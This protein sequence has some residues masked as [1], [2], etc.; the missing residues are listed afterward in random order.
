MYYESQTIKI[1][2]RHNIQAG[3]YTIRIRLNDGSLNSMYFFNLEILSNPD[4]DP[5]V[6]K[7]IENLTESEL[8]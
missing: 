5:V 3:E 4:K 8:E 1:Y 2:P 7:P 6:V